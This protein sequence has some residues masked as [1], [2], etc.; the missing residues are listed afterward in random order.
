MEAL[1]GAMAKDT[2]DAVVTVRIVEPVTLP[3][4][5][6]MDAVPDAM[7]V[8]SPESLPRLPTVAIVVS[9]EL[10]VADFVKSFILLS[11]NVPVAINC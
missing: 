5:A 4:V 8:T 10:Q 3:D 1:P 7:V 11:V 9:E 6:V 2:S